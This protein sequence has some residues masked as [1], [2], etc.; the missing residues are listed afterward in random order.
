ME[1][2]YNV[3]PIIQCAQG[4]QLALNVNF[5]DLALV[6]SAYKLSYVKSRPKNKKV[7]VDI[8][9]HSLSNLKHPAGTLIIYPTRSIF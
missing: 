2:E 8:I 1:L 6:N 5:D 7:T 3:Y 9:I 4:C